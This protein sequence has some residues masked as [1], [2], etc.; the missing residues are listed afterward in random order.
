MWRVLKRTNYKKVSYGIAGKLLQDDTA[1]VRRA[2][3]AT[4]DP[5]ERSQGGVDGIKQ[6]PEEE[7]QRKLDQPGGRPQ[8]H[9]ESK[10]QPQEEI[11]VLCEG[12]RRWDDSGTDIGKLVHGRYS[13]LVDD[14]GDDVE[15]HGAED[16][17]VVDVES[18]I[19]AILVEGSKGRES[20]GEGDPYPHDYL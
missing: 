15:E 2:R 7:E 13:D 14:G 16:E 19:P 12:G 17:E 6:A 5:P 9:V 3:D 11:G 20:G 18:L 4:H 8:H 1:G 10:L